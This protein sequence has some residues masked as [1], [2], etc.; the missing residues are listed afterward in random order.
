MKGK[1]VVFKAIGEPCDVLEIV[2]NN[3]QFNENLPILMRM[4]YC[5]I[6]PADGLRIRGKF[7]FNEQLPA[8][9]GGEGVGIIEAFHE[10]YSSE[11]FKIG[12]ICILPFGGTWSQYKAVNPNEIIVMPASIDPMQLCMFGINAAS[13]LFLV[14]STGLQ[15]NEW[16]IQNAANSAVGKLII[17]FAKQHGIKTVN[18]VRRNDVVDELYA[19]GADVV[20]LDGEDLKLRTQEATGNAPIKVALDAVAG[21]ASGRLVDTLSFGGRLIVYGLLSDSSLTLPAS[22]VAF[23]SITVGGFSRMACLRNLN[24]ESRKAFFA[25]IAKW[26]SEGLFKFE[27][28]KIYSFQNVIEAFNHSET[29]KSGKILLSFE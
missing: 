26:H 29:S 10:S 19:L 24:P 20:L 3:I 14:K 16:L 5:P 23:H 18:V 9:V 25:D 12:D 13:A 21:S 4:L 1:A 27:I 22:R 28:E 7:G 11:D 6:N 15:S 8:I 2:E 17:K